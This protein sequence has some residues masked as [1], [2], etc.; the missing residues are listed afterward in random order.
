MS[1]G[2]LGDRKESNRLKNEIVRL[3]IEIERLQNELTDLKRKREEFFQD[4]YKQGHDDAY[5]EILLR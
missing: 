4:G 1:F 5:R 3:K 2:F